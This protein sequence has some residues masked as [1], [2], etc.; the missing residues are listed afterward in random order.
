VLGTP[1]DAWY[2][3]LGLSAAG[4]AI[5]GTAAGLPTAA[6][7]EPAPVART[8][9]AVASS[10]H[11]G[12]ASHP[13]DAVS[14]RLGPTGIGLRTDGGVAREQFAYGPVTPVT[15]DAEELYAVLTGDPPGR[16]FAS[17]AEFSDRA[18]R[19]RQAAPEWRPAPARLLVRRVS[20][21]DTDVTLVG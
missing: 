2:V 13:L 7:P 19:A 8:V 17:P 21:G 1:V 9:D 12:T 6:P 5:L 11:P 20:W 10:P 3:W 4:I 18:A 14:I 16:V 15:P